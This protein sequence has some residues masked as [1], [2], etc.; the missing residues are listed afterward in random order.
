MLVVAQDTDHASDLVATIQEDDFYGGRY[1]NRVITVHSNQRG[2]EKDETI[3]RLMAVEHPDEPTEIVVHVNMLKEGWDVTNLYTI[4]PL[5]AANSR[6]LVEQ[7]IGR[8]LRL[9]YGRKVGVSAV[10]RL[11][12]VAHDR[13]QQIVDEA[14]NPDSI[15]RTG[16]VI[17]RDIPEERRQVVTVPSMLGAA[18]AEPTGAQATPLASDVRSTGTATVLAPP[19]SEIASPFHTPEARQVAR[20]TLDVIQ[21]RFT[22]LPRAEDL[23]MPEVRLQI[24]AAVKEEMLPVQGTLD[25]VETP[26]FEEVIAQVTNLVVERT[27]DIPR[28]IVVPTGEV[29]SGFRD[30]DL[31]LG[32]RLQ[33]VSQDILI[34]HLRTHER[35]RLESSPVAGEERPENYIVRRLIDYD[36]VS[37]ENNAELLYKLAGQVVGYLQSYLHD[38][39]DV[40]NVLQYHEQRLAELI[41]AQMQEHFWQQATGYEA[42]VS[43][44]FLTLDET[45]FNAPEGVA[46]SDFRATIQNRADIRNMLF[47]GFAKSLY[48]VQKFD[49]DSERRFAVL[50]ED[51]M[52]VQKWFKPARTQ[53]QIYY[54]Q[55]SSYEPDFVVETATTHYLCEPKRADQ[56][57]NDEVLQKAAAASAWCVHASAHAEEHGTKPWAYLLIPHDSIS[58]NATVAG[59]AARFAYTAE[60]G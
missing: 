35:E 15:I 43:R 9:P 1:K 8:G 52:S 19:R 24:I 14:N 32:F 28:I 60:S 49:S 54:R 27:I 7:S 30:F 5:R 58:T 4:V 29:T 38:P 56:M 48:P 45:S 2:K 22:R 44:G 53:L 50:L 23:Q 51:D 55:D 40:R 21:R 13:F 6:T 31:E 36:D 3:E 20:T 33:P 18:F 41:H 46:I 57:T 25:V 16:V 12:I 34:Q 26:N 42:Q 39:D 37:Y 47:G 17:G 10:D 11:T 59:L